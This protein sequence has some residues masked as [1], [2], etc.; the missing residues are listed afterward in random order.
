MTSS[1][2]RKLIFGGFNVNF[3]KTITLFLVDG[4]PNGLTCSYLS[5]W[6]GQCI[7][8]PR[9]LLSES[10]NRNEV[11]NSGVYFLFGNSD[12]SSDFPKVY[13]GEGENVYKRLTSHIKDKE[14]WNEAIVFSS[15]DDNMTKAHIKYLENRLINIIKQNS[16]Y[17]L[18]NSN[19]GN[20]TKLPEYAVADMEAYLENIKVVLPSLG[21]DVFTKVE[22][23][24]RKKSKHFSLEL[25]HVSAKGYLSQNG[26]V[27]LKDSEVS[28]TIR[29][30]LSNGYRK[31]RENLIS[32]FA[33]VEV[34][35]ILK[36]SIDVEFRSPTEA[37]AIISGYS[38]SGRQ[39]WKNTYGKTIKEI[40]EETYKE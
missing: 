21:Y 28:K 35:G 26:F 15:K 1:V 33:I 39:S 3:G 10:R 29:E 32:T 18:I 31:K 13:V 34:E 30:S 11:N 2:V 25:K 17:E 36:F 27:V 24:E 20:T 16:N 37:A 12:D 19:D 23:T 4:S 14:F 7:K 38:I 9:N 6:N 8:I 5:N 22:K 40:E